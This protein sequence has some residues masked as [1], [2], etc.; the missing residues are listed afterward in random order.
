MVSRNHSERIEKIDGAAGQEIDQ[1]PNVK[2]S[3]GK[4]SFARRPSRRGTRPSCS[5]PCG[6]R[7]RIARA[8]RGRVRVRLGASSEVES[9]PDRRWAGQAGFQ[10]GLAPARSPIGAIPATRACPRPSISRAPRTSRSAEPVFPAPKRIGESDGSE[11]FGYE[12]GVV[13][14]FKVQAA[15]P[16]KPV[17]LALTAEFAV[18]EKICLPARGG[19]LAGAAQGR[20]L[21]LRCRDRGGARRAPRTV[22]PQGVR[23]NRGRRRRRLAALPAREPGRARDLFVEPPEGWWVSAA[24]APGEAGHDCFR[25]PARRRRPHRSR[26]G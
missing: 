26:C 7:I 9:A 3:L 16:A 24:A 21:A 8:R 6:R 1:E 23:R 19:G 14:P 11:A 18:C 13:F 2:R 25:L 12:R 15:D 5:C 10:I 17:T 22:E 4:P 20:W